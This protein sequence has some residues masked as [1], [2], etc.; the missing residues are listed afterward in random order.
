MTSQKIAATQDAEKKEED[1][2]QGSKATWENRL[3]SVG[4]REKRR[5]EGSEGEREK[6]RRRKRKEG[7]E[8]EDDN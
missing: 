3:S 5:R 2:L 4:D 7:S 8:E 1:A 6:R